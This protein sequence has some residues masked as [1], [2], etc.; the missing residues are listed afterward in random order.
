MAFLIDGDKDITTKER[1]IVYGRILRRGRP[2][3]ILIG[4]IEVEHAHAQGIYAA[5]KKTFAVLGDQ[6]S[7]WLEKVIALGADGA[8]V[9]LGSKGGVI[10]PL[11]QEADMF[12]G[13]SN[14]CLLFQRNE[15]ILPQGVCGLEQLLVT[16]EA[17]AARPKPG[18]RLS[19]FLADVRLQRRQQKEV[20]WQSTNSR[21]GVNT[22]LAKEE[23]VGLKLLIARMFK[24]KTYLSLW[25]LMLTRE[26]YCLEY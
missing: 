5:S 1:V 16:T 15:I 22:E 11:Q 23:F 13:I 4:H 6:C 10:A 7:N 21:N 25:E 14:F 24:D 8:T 12:S 20:K 2:V 18:G 17:M 9:N 19:E 26:P 3:N